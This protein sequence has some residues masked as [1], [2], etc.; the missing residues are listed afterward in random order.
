MSEQADRAR[1]CLARRGSPP[2]APGAEACRAG[3][4]GTG[5]TAR[6]GAPVRGFGGRS[7]VSSRPPTTP[8]SG[9]M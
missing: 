1:D 6:R 2:Q 3:G 4:G 8:M 7:A 9:E 5:G